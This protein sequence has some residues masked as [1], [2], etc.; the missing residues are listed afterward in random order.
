MKNKYLIPKCVALSLQADKLMAMSTDKLPIDP[1][2]PGIP[3]AREDNGSNA[4]VWNTEW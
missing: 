2:T 3:A 4:S 1:E